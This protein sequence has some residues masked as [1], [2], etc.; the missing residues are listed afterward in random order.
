MSTYFLVS[1]EERQRAEKKN[2]VAKE[3][4]FTPRWFDKTD[5]IC[6]TTWD[7]LEVYRYNGKYTEHRAAV[8]NSDSVE[9]IDIK[10]IEF[11]PWQYENLAAA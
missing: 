4:E 5:E 6:P 7:D 1:L 11:N 3:Q 10:S 9:A 2:R 8:D